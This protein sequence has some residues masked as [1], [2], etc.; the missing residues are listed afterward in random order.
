MEYFHSLNGS[1]YSCPDHQQASSHL[2]H[3]QRKGL[4]A[5]EGGTDQDHQEPHLLKLQ[6]HQGVHT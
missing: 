6:E 3:D 4:K 1:F 2:F 5:Q